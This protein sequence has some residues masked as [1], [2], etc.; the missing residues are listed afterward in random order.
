[1]YDPQHEEEEAQARL[2]WQRL[3]AGTSDFEKDQL[4]LLLCFLQ[5]YLQVCN[6]YIQ[7]FLKNVSF[8]NFITVSQAVN[9]KEK[10]KKN[11]ER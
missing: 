10:R 4:T 2:D 3:P 5:G 7:D 6:S 9:I 11:K 1:M 8:P